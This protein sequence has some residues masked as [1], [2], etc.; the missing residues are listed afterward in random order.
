[1]AGCLKGG[2]KSL[3]LPSVV[4]VEQDLQFDKIGQAEVDPLDCFRFS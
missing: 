4:H 2:K 1:M 3:L